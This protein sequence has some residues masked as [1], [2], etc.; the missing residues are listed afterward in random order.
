[1]QV[2]QA[3]EGVIGSIYNLQTSAGGGY[4]RYYSAIFRDLPDRYDYP[5]YYVVIKEPRCLHGILVHPQFFPHQRDGNGGALPR[6]SGGSLSR[7]LKARRARANRPVVQ[8]QENMRKGLYSSAHA[9]AFDLFLIWSNAREYNEQGSLVYAD[10]DK[11]EV[12]RTHTVERAGIEPRPAGLHGATLAR[13]LPASPALRIA[14][15]LRRSAASSTLNEFSRTGAQGEADQAD[16]LA[17]LVC[18]EP[19]SS[20][21]RPSHADGIGIETDAHHQARRE[22]SDGWS[23]RR[24][25]CGS[26]ESSGTPLTPDAPDASQPGIARAASGGRT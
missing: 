4:K 24:T 22:P 18:R 14:P 5:D 16:G 8:L 10:A 7:R 13:T 20:S 2:Q 26:L 1:M 25:C 17:Q 15:S 21:N 9:V 12:R 23:G 3:L 6:R 11:L 19:S